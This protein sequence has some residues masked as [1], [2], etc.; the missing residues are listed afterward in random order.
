MDSSTLKVEKKMKYKF[1]S[2]LQNK[3]KYIYSDKII[4][5]VYLDINKH[6]VHLDHEVENI[7]LDYIDFLN[8]VKLFFLEIN[9]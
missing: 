2:I 3:A 4:Q 8:K 7:C 5:I 6:M 1:K 9:K